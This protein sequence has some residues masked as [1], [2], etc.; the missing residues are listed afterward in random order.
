MISSS[1][2]REAGVNASTS[3]PARL[4]VP[5]QTARSR[6]AMQK[7]S[8]GSMSAAPRSTPSS[9]NSANSRRSSNFRYQAVL[10]ARSVTG[11]LIWVMRSSPAMP[12]RVAG[13]SSVVVMAR[14]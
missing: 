11:S 10:R 8:R 14:R 1:T 2:A 7:R 12:R 6:S 4:G 13:S 9:T 3:K 5:A